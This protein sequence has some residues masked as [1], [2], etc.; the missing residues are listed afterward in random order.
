MCAVIDRRYGRIPASGHSH[1]SFGT[2]SCLF[3]LA[4]CAIGA[5]FWSDRRVPSDQAH[6]ERARQ[7]TATI[8]S[9]GPSFIKTAQVFG[10]RA[11]IVP[12]IYLEGG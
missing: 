3:L 8:A 12:Q 6:R 10:I 5:G 7:L 1:S 4:F 11:D 2:G 9:L